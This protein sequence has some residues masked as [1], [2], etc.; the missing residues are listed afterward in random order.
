MSNIIYKRKQK[1]I[2]TIWF[3]CLLD[4]LVCRWYAVEYNNLTPNFVNKIF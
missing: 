4:P 3:V 1:A 2:F